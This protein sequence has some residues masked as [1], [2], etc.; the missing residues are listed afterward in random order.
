VSW[1]LVRLWT[2]GRSSS[3]SLEG[4]SSRAGFRFA[5]R[6]GG[7]AG[8]FG[9][10]APVRPAPLAPLGGGSGSAKPGEQA[11]D[12][13][14]ES[15]PDRDSPQHAGEARHRVSTC[16]AWFEHVQRA[17]VDQISA[18]PLVRA[19]PASGSSAHVGWFVE[20]A[21]T[22][23]TGE[24]AL[25]VMQTARSSSER[26]GQ[27]PSS[28]VSTSSAAGTSASSALSVSASSTGVRAYLA[29]K[30]PKRRRSSV[31]DEP[32]GHSVHVPVHETGSQRRAFIG[33]G[34]V[35]RT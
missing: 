14:R 30:A 1:W 6:Q 28:A 2:S 7:P 11:G 19:D 26:T 27:E 10:Y 33:Y 4:Q 24:S 9:G 23:A 15:E 21:P 3:R 16:A 13:H 35:S 20:C 29:N 22:P 32:V 12:G 17:R 25:A 8:A 31:S 34:A 5:S 18:R